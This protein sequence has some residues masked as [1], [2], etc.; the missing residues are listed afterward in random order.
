[1]KT[2]HSLLPLV[3]NQLKEETDYTDIL[4]E[5]TDLSGQ[6]SKNINFYSS[7]FKHS[8]FSNGKFHKLRLSECRLENSDLANADWSESNHYPVC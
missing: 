7:V 2:N 1:M 8:N 6:T 4:I 3:N 5:N